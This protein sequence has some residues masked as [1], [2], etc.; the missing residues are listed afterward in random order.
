MEVNDDDEY[1]DRPEGA[2]EGRSS[3]GRGRRSGQ[4]RHLASAQAFSAD[5]V[6]AAEGQRSVVSA[7]HVMVAS[8]VPILAVTAL[9]VLAG[10]PR[11]LGVIRNAALV[12]AVV[13]LGA[14]LSMGVDAGTKV[15]LPLM[16]LVVAVA[17][18]CG[19][20]EAGSLSR[21]GRRAGRHLPVRTEDG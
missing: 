21:D 20:V 17:F 12:A 9:A 7:S 14:P 8:V 2:V 19:S 6:V 5:L 13:S 11:R 15:A 1:G 10:T 18:A 3:G 16:H 4:R